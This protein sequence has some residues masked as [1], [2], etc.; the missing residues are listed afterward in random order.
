MHKSGEDWTYAVTSADGTRFLGRGRH[1]ACAACHDSAKPD[2]LFGL[3][4]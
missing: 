1:E 3:P 2:R 4:R